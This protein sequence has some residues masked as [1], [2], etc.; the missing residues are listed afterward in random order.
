MIIFTIFD[1]R[2]P[3]LP[4]LIL[5][6]ILLRFLYR[7]IFLMMEW[8]GAGVGVLSQIVSHLNV[9]VTCT[10]PLYVN[11]TESLLFFSIEPCV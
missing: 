4:F 3:A 2:A 8:V 9:I 10:Q 5:I 11:W 7:V 1:G 6:C